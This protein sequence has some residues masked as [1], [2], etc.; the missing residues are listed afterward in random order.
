MGVA[1]R[2][3][4]DVGPLIAAGRLVRLLPHW[5]MEPAP[6]LALVPSRKG[7]SARVRSFIE[8]AKTAFDPPPWRTKG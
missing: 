3:E 8:A 4:W 6:I 1:A 2:S 5:E 7:M